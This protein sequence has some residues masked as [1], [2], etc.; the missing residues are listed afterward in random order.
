LLLN[1][2]LAWGQQDLTPRPVRLNWD[3]GAKG[4]EGVSTAETGQLQCMVSFRARDVLK[5]FRI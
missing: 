4:I 2:E 5:S 3:P 1:G